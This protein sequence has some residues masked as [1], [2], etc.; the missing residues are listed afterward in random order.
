M[1]GEFRHA[2][3]TP[4][5]DGFGLFWHPCLRC[6]RKESILNRVRRIEATG[7]VHLPITA[8]TEM[9][10]ESPRRARN[11]YSRIELLA[12]TV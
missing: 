12:V 9:M 1:L 2:H 6:G 3:L 11:P 10:R 8:Q 4:R 5:Q 7:F